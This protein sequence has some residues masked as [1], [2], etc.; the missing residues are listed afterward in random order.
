[1]KVEEE[2]DLPITL[3]E[4]PLLIASRMLGNVLS[5]GKKVWA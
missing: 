4:T 5:K 2:I 1:V 3:A